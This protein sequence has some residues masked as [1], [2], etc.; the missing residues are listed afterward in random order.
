[1]EDIV[2]SGKTS[3]GEHCLTVVANR[4]YRVVRDRRAVPCDDR[5]PVQ[6][7]QTHRPSSN[8]DALP[9]LAT[10]EPALEPN[11]PL[12]DVLLAGS[13]H[14]TRGAVTSLET[15]LEVGAVH[16]RVRVVGPRRIELGAGGQLSFTRPEHFTEMALLWDHAFGGRDVHAE[17]RLRPGRG[18]GRQ[19]VQDQGPISYPRNG[20]GRGYFL[21]LDRER[22]AGA[23]LPNLE[24]P[25][26]PVTA[27][28]L[29]SKNTY[30]WIDR[31]VAACYEAIDW[32]T[33]PR[34]AF[35][36]PPAYDAPT[37]PIHELSSGAVLPE[38]LTRPFEL[39][40]PRDPRVCNRAPA[41]LAVCRLTGRERVKLT[42]LHRE[43]A[44]LEFDLPD[45]TPKFTLDLPGV[46]ERKL[47]PILSTVSIEPDA[48]RVVLTWAASLRVAMP[49]PEEMT[50]AMRRV[51]RWERRAA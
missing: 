32:F 20:S 29:L 8:P 11:K 3:S 50:K 45:D 51:V 47:E 25:T 39:Q 36:I 21:D 24:D 26:D 22:L 12:T 10:E 15:S 38:D 13:A 14:S 5:V 17:E 43:H 1:M 9:A 35:L 16:K 31:P 48:D 33:F 2:L 34:A 41:G 40:G 18:F 42:N 49:Y 23:A 46:G 28:R 19:R 37:R 44:H 4:S 30:D 6:D 27:E 7:E